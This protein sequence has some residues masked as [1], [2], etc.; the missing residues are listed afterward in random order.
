[1]V[2][3]PVKGMMKSSYIGWTMPAAL[4]MSNGGILRGTTLM[5]GE[6]GPEMY[7]PLDSRGARFLNDLLGRYQAN[8]E[9]RQA[10][11]AAY[12]VVHNYN[13]STTVND[14]SVHTGTVTVVSA[15]PDDMARKLR[16]RARQSAL[17]SKV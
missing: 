15:N 16:A 3:T 12:S 7:L 17:A 10:R 11:T 13:G 9:V 4:A 5:A 14:S 8:G 6:G 1:V 2:R